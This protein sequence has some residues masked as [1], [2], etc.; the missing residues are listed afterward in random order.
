MT[1]YLAEWLSNYPHF[2]EKAQKDP[3]LTRYMSRTKPEKPAQQVKESEWK[4]LVKLLKQSNHPS[5]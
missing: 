1:N 2:I 5:H 4:Q 3:N